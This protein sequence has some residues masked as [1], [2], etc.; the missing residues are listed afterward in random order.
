VAALKNMRFNFDVI[1]KGEM[2]KNIFIVLSLSFLMFLPASISYSLENEDTYNKEMEEIIYKLGG[3]KQERQD[4]VNRIYE[5]IKKNDMR[6][7]HLLIN[8][9]NNPDKLISL[10]SEA[11]LY[12]ITE[13]NCFGVCVGNKE[14]VKKWKQF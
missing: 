13:Y 9:L 4:S 2:M 11:L 3:D 10:E 12:R 14:G 6:V 5:E 8:A 1:K 7:I